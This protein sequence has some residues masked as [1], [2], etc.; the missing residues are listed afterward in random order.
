M[1]ENIELRIKAAI[2]AA[3]SAKTLGELR[4]SMKELQSLSLE[5]GESGK[6]FKGLQNALAQSKDKVD[7]L[8]DSVTTLRGSGVE[9]LSASFNLF[10]DSLINADYGK[11]KIAFQ[12]IGTAMKAIPIFLIIEGIRY[13][14]ENFEKLK[15]S[16]GLLGKAL[17]AIGDVVSTLIQGFKDLTDWIGITNFA[18]EDKAEKTIQAAKTEQDAVTSR[19]DAEIK[20]AQAAGKNTV[21]LEKLKQ[22]AI[23]DSADVQIKAITDV[24]RVNGEVTEE[25]IKQLNELKKQRQTAEL[26]Q[27]AI[28]AK[29]KKEEEDKLKDLAKKAEEAAE[30]QRDL[31]IKRAEETQKLANQIRQI[32]IGLIEDVEQRR[33]QQ[34]T[35]EAEL[36]KQEINN[37]KA[38]A[39]VKAAAV[40]EV[41]KQLQSNITNVQ[42][43]ELDKRQKESETANA[44]RFADSELEVQKIMEQQ[45]VRAE[46]NQLQNQNDL[47]SQLAY[48]EAKKNQELANTELTEA[49]KA[50]IKE[51]YRIQT[52][53]AERA[54]MERTFTT[55]QELTQGLQS[56]SDLYFTVK[57]ANLQK[58]SKEELKAAEQQFKINKALSLVSATISGIQAVINAYQSGA[59]VPVY[60]AILGPVYAIA[61]A[62]AVGANIAKISSQQFQGGGTGAGSVTAPSSSG[63]GSSVPTPSLGTSGQSTLFSQQLVNQPGSTTNGTTTGTPSGEPVKVMVTE[64]DI[65]STQNKVKVIENQAKF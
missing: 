43:E 28:A 26:E 62:A 3:E 21:E 19:Y 65:T 49:D 55:A 54:S 11:A 60:G 22:Q 15:S 34:L 23:I 14:I 61:A 24:V 7:D 1:A 25:Q 44:K 32:E 46:L 8:K 52:E 35:F 38:D 50:L 37:S 41:E 29:A 47:E 10:K 5:V 6:G 20:L 31:N 40:L 18:I 58:G 33:I 48:L 59:A 51:K 17:T 13:L 2:D 4:S 27:K 64:T 45:V 39:E 56:L 30:R 57:K 16:G 53:E 9:K 12:G 42:K 63:A 36:R